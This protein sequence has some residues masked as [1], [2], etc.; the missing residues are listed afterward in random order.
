VSVQVIEASEAFS[1]E[2][3]LPVDY[4]VRLDAAAPGLFTGLG[5]F[6]T[7]AGLLLAFGNIDPTQSASSIQPLIG[8]MHVAFINSLVGVSLALIWSY[9]SRNSRHAFDVACRR[10]ARAAEAE[11]GRRTG[12]DQVLAA[13]GTLQ[14]SLF[15]GLG[16]LADE[17]GV[18]RGATLS[19]SAE[20]LD[21]LAPTL[22]KTFQALIETPFERLDAAA[23]AYAATI[24]EAAEVQR[25]ITSNLAVSVGYLGETKSQL[26]AS[27]ETVTAHV[28][29]FRS[30]LD[31][32]EVQAR[33]ATE[34]V[35]QAKSAAE[36]LTTTTN[37]IRSVGERHGQ[38]ASALGGAV[39]ELRATGGALNGV[40]GQFQVASERLEGAAGH[41]E[42]LSMRAAEE[43]AEAARGELQRAVEEMSKALRQFGADTAASYEASTAKVVNAVDARMSDLTDRL[44]AELTTLAARLP[45]TM[46]QMT[47]ATRDVRTQVRNAVRS[48][49]ESVR[50][51]DSRTRQSLN[52]QLVDYDTALAEA[53]GRFSGTLATW[54]GK[55]RDLETI[56]KAIQDGLDHGN[57]PSANG[58]PNPPDHPPPP[59]LAP[60]TTPVA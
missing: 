21:K 33:A 5:I 23:A 52:A 37:T 13:F 51:L 57:G 54:D 25:Q 36:S 56:A 8:G 12:G 44:S 14:E 27:L 34:I 48:L 42:A 29:H 28:Q 60:F 22:E 41:I 17:I 38:L 30:S 55:L 31:Q 45:E 11:Y 59:P 26:A 50:H 47:D 43:A 58:Q 35:S 6:G 19:S 15:V 7:F 40:A 9:F 16:A 20:L 49:E 2:L 32:C 39:T 3:L 53:V 18:L 1:P 10:L 24:N 4:N 46:E